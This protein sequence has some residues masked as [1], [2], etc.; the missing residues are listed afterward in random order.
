MLEV[1]VYNP[2][3]RKIDTLK[4]EE[5]IFGSTVNVSLVKQAIIAYRNNRRQGT[6]ATKGRGEVEGST[7]KLYKQKHTGNARR[8][9]IRTNVMRG[10]GMAF[11]KKPRD[12]RTP[13]PKKMR[14]AALHSALL[15]KII[16]QDLMVID[17]LSVSSPKTKTMAGLM[18]NLKINRS[19]LLAT[20]GLDRNVYLSSRNL[21]DLTVLP[22]ADLN[23]FEVATRQKMLVTSKAMTALMAREAK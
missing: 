11:G 2:D 6:V 13:F 4:V 18:K 14:K 21:P 7:K 17:G 8:G 19:C 22:A 15:A 3:G 5:E 23:A 10:G 20:D 12:F 9:P 16:G 1:P